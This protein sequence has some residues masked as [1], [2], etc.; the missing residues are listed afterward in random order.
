MIIF[1]RVDVVESRGV[2]EDLFK[3]HIEFHPY[4]P[5]MYLSNYS[6]DP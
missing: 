5:K 1:N 3:H 4:A 6:Y 2:G